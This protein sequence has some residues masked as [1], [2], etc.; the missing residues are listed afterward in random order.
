MFKRQGKETAYKVLKKVGQGTFG[1]VYLGKDLATNK[2]VALKKI[3]VTNEVDGVPVTL[4]REISILRA[5][6]H[7]NIISTLGSYVKDEESVHSMKTTWYSVFIV[8]PFMETDLSHLIKNTIIPIEDMM[9][10]TKQILQGLRYIHARNIIHRDIKPSN[11]LIGPNKTVKIADFGL[12]RTF[13]NTYMTRGV[14]SRW[15]RAPELLLG[16]AS[17]G[18]SIDMWSC[19]CIVGEMLLRKP[20]FI[21]ESD[22]GQLSAISIVCG[23][24][25]PSMFD[26]SVHS[27]NLS[28]SVIGKGEESKI[29]RTFSS[30]SK[31]LAHLV[32][33]MLQI[34]PSRR[35]TAKASLAILKESLQE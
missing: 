30:C 28:L 21:S 27:E 26:E 15:Y 3:R 7:K 5:L 34:D 19:G 6:R 23:E 4:I 12:S 8:F 29:L 10:Y 11:I 14:V 2:K 20:L 9:S 25:D 32:D 17:Y 33:Q 22:A 31:T 18:K 24:I 1:K 35:I 16:S 13:V